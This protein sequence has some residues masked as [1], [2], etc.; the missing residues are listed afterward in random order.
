MSKFVAGT[1]QPAMRQSIEKALICKSPGFIVHR[2]LPILEQAGD[3]AIPLIQAPHLVAPTNPITILI[4]RA[5]VLT[6][7]VAAAMAVGLEI[8]GKG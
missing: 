1:A 4:R 2:H 8:T 7:A 5:V 3:R 6:L